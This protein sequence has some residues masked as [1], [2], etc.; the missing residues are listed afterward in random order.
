LIKLSTCAAAAPPWAAAVLPEAGEEAAE[1]WVPPA[2][3]AGTV[4]RGEGERAD[5]DDE[6]DGPVPPC[7][8][9][10]VAWR[11]GTVT[12]AGGTATARPPWLAAQPAVPAAPHPA[13]VVREPTVPPDAG[14]EENTP[15]V[16]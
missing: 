9:R 3:V 12:T 11:G 4:G 10:A 1:A 5:D 15:R 7:R 13:A 6:A 16:R 14:P 2:P 8:A